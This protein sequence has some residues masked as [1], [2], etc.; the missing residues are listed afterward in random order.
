MAALKAETELF[1]QPYT[2]LDAAHGA[3]Q[4]NVLEAALAAGQYQVAMDGAQD[5][6]RLALAGMHYYQTYALTATDA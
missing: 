1:F 2:K 4:L 5:L 6:M 3:Q